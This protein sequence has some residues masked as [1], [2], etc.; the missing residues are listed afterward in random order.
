MGASS[1]P[2]ERPHHTARWPAWHAAAGDAL[3]SMPG[4]AAANACHQARDAPARPVAGLAVVPTRIGSRAPAA[5]PRASQGPPWHARPGAASRRAGHQRP[6]TPT[7]T[8]SVGPGGAFR[9]PWRRPCR[10]RWQVDR[11][12]VARSLAAPVLP[13][14]RVAGGP[15]PPPVLDPGEHDPREELARR[16]LDSPG[17]DHRLTQGH[18]RSLACVAGGVP[19]RAGWRSTGPF[20]LDVADRSR[21]RWAA[22][23]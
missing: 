12:A 22:D 7:G 13:G 5:A 10:C 20:G 8:A 3:A 2:P 15:T 9:G 11:S 1:G 17:L 19:N 4:C 6:M 14:G 16:S 18:R 23:W 21:I